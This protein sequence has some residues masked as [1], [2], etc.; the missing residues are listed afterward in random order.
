MC[1]G[2]TINVAM[3]GRRGLEALDDAIRA[4]PEDRL[5]VESDVD[6]AAAARVATCRAVQLVATARGWTPARTASTTSANAQQ[7]L[8]CEV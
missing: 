6:D 1:T 2:H 4:V 5:L 7:W 3:N 8:C